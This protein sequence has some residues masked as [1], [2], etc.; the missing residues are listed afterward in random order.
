VAF[1]WLGTL[2]DHSIDRL[3]DCQTGET[4]PPSTVYLEATAVKRF[5]AGIVVG[6]V[7]GVFGLAT[8]LQYQVDKQLRQL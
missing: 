3:A 2:G 5:L 8:F 6:V 4:L 7:V 1:A